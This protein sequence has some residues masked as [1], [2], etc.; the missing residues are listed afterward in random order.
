MKFSGVLLSLVVLPPSLA[1]AQ[2]DHAALQRMLLIQSNAAY[3]AMQEKN[4]AA[5]QATVTP[6]ILEVGSGGML[7]PATFPQM[8]RDCRLTSYHLSQPSLRVLNATA[9]VLAYKVNQVANCGKKPD[10]S[11]TY[12]T[13]V[14]VDRGN[15]WLIAAHI[16][17]GAE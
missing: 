5:L 6:D 4:L 16:E 11:I 14:F 7:G 8:L 3:Q 17:A 10:P 15:R 2:G 9:A 1:L 13:D 12:A